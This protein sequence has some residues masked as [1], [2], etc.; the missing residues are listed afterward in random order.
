M[1]KFI[2]AMFFG[3]LTM[4]AAAYFIARPADQRKADFET[5]KNLASRIFECVKNYVTELIN[6]TQ[7]TE[8]TA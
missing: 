6:P 1:L 2:G 8:E 4:S 7:T 5:A 3:L